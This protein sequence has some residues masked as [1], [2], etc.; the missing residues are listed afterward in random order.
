MKYFDRNCLIAVLAS[1]SILHNLWGQEV[2]V[3]DA[4]TGEAL[5]NV[6][7]FSE[8]GDINRLRMVW[9]KLIYKLFLPKEE[10]ILS[11]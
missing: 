6:T 9:E 11:C 8:N 7:L 10:S 1:L 3:E 5:E 4:V 2:W